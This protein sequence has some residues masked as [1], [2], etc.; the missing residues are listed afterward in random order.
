EGTRVAADA[1]SNTVIV[2]GTPAS[3]AEARK[4][5]ISL[6]QPGGATPITRMFRLNYA[7]AETVT[8][9]LRGVLGQGESADNPIAT[10]LGSNSNSNPFA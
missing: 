1:R 8:D 10:S 2:R 6:D 3:V 7:D 5:L 9:V 4:M